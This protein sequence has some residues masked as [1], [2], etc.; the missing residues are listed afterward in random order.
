MAKLTSILTFSGS[1]EGLT[2]YKLE[3][4]EKEVLRRKGGPSR[5]QVRNGSNFT[6]TRKNNK[7]TAGRSRASG[8]VL[9]TF[10]LLRPVVDQS[11]AGRL[12]GLLKVVQEQDT[13]SPYGQRH[14]LL[15]RMPG[16]LEGFALRKVY[17]LESIIRNPVSCTVDKAALAAVV[18]VPALIPGVNFLSPGAQPF[19]RLVAALG[20]VPDLYYDKKTDHYY[21]HP[22]YGIVRAHSALTDWYPVQG[23]SPATTLRLQ[24]PEHPGTDAFSLVLTVGVQWGTP[25]AGGQVELVKKVK[26]AR[27]ERVV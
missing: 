8:L 18:D 23:G 15:S 17:P 12:N 25:A 7:E 22:D 26:S 21:P 9:D 3:G 20:I 6:L 13:A 11:C 24:L 27:I 19:Y 5:E 16:L 4:V 1:L 10:G 14:V 2:A